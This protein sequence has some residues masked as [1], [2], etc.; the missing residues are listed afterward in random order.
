ML[1]IQS[2]VGFERDFAYTFRVPVGVVCAIT[3]FNAPI[4]TVLHKIAPA[5]AGGNS[6]VLKPAARR[7]CSLKLAELLTD[8]G[9]PRGYLNVLTGPGRARSVAVRTPDSAVLHVHR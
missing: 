9:V 1:P 7:L 5:L 6:V 4:S 8:A 2:A 3:P